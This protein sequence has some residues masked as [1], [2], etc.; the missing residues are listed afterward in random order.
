M[1]LPDP[2]IAPGLIV[3]F[4]VDGKPFNIT[5]PVGAEHVEG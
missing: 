2:A 5:E 4:P 1:V 3:Q